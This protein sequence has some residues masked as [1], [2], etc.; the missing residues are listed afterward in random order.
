MSRNRITLKMNKV[1]WDK[2][3]V[4]SYGFLLDPSGHRLD[5]LLNKAPLKFP[6]PTSP[7]NL[8]SFFGLANQLCNFTNEIANTLSPIKIRGE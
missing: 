8:Q 3:E 5:P 2:K 1:Q 6:T 4:L 7:T